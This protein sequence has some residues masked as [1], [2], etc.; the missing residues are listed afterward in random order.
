MKVNIGPIWEIRGGAIDFDGVVHPTDGIK[1]I[2]ELGLTFTGPVK[3]RGKATNTGDGFLIEVVL[4]FEYQ[5]NCN[6]CLDP[7]LDGQQVR[8]NEEFIPEFK[9]KPGDLAFGF[10]GENIDLTACIEEQVML[11]LPMKF[12]CREDCR[13]FC[14]ECGA[15]LNLG[16]CTCSESK[17]DSR[18]EKLKSLLATEGGGSNGKPNK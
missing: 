14:P 12:L 18:F 15:H 1:G 13:G 3:V 4:S 9:R 5:A 8:F 2:E 17:I 10:Q 6:R 16:Q 7:F 11:A